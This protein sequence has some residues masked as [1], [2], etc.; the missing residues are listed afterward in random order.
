MAYLEAFDSILQARHQVHVCVHSL[1]ANI[2]LNKDLTRGK[3]QDL[4]G[5]QEHRIIGNMCGA[6]S[7]WNWCRRHP[8]WK[9]LDVPGDSQHAPAKIDIRQ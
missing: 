6:H 9:S 4:V 5:L 8:P 3:T 2:A 7:S 1:V